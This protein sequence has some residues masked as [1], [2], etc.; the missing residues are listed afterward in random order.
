MDVHE[1]TIKSEWKVNKTQFY[2]KV[3]AFTK[4]R[5]KNYDKIYVI[6]ACVCSLS[7]LQVE[8]LLLRHRRNAI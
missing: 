7:Y 4:I 1:N 8:N 2:N 6:M 3:N 5:N